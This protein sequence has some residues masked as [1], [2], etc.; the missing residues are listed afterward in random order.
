MFVEADSIDKA[1]D[2]K[3]QASG[4]VLDYSASPREF[5][6]VN[7][8]VRTATGWDGAADPRGGGAAMGD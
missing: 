7:A 6:A 8:I 5:G 4:Y 1:T 3:L 2:A